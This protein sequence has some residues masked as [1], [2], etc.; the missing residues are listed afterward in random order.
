MRV[1]WPGLLM[2]RVFVGERVPTRCSPK[3]TVAVLT[4]ILRSIPVPLKGTSTEGSSESSLLTVNFPSRGPRAEGVNVTENEADVPGSIGEE[5][6][7][8]DRAKSAASDPPDRTIEE[9]SR[10][11]SESL[12]SEV[13]LI[14]TS[15][16]ADE[17]PRQK[18]PNERGVVGETSISRS[19][20]D[21]ANA[22]TP[23]ASHTENSAA[24]G[25]FRLMEP[26]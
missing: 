6:V 8:D 18:L 14:V 17:T 20:G 4:V 2:M 21:C 11:D 22:T 25:A 3:A 23:A 7:S 16:G 13:L 5:G 9:I 15:F 19:L 26:A 1:S 12:P 24:T 10:L